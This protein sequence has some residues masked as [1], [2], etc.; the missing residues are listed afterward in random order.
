[1][2]GAVHGEFTGDVGDDLAVGEAAGGLVARE[3]LPVGRVVGLEHRAGEVVV[4]ADVDGRVAEGDDR[5]HE[6]LRPD[7]AAAAHRRP[8]HEQRHGQQRHRGRRHDML[9][10]FT[11]VCALAAPWPTHTQT[12]AKILDMLI[13][14]RRPSAY[15]WYDASTSMWLAVGRVELKASSNLYRREA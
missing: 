6:R 2:S 3:V 15:I 11:L 10:L 5:R 1:M 14:D 7:A 12:V 9:A 8:R 13:C 4:V